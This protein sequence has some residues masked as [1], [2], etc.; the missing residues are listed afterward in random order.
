MLVNR[1]LVLASRSPRRR[2]LLDQIGLTFEVCESG[3]DEEFPPGADPRTYVA[4]LS[5]RKASA[6]AQSYQDAIIIGA[7]T[8]VVVDRTLLGKPAD[9]TEASRMLG[10][11]SG[12]SHEVFTGLTLF[13]RPSNKSVTG[14][15]RTRVTFRP[16]SQDEIRDY[17][18]SG[19]PMDKAGAYGIQDDRGAVFVERI[20]GCFYNV[21]G[22]P[23]AQFYVML[24]DFL[25]QLE[26]S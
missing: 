25:K 3:V 14:V 20:E 17:V 15:E 4:A 8:I 21:V 10:M 6:V 7:D 26:L 19:S 24:R 23:L 13:D 2:R 16:L 5:K 12:K 1:K 22:L 11:L 18:A 9:A